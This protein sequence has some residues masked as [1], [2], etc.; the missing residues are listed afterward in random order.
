MTWL[1]RL[2]QG[3]KKPGDKPSTLSAFARFFQRK[4][5]D[6]TTLEDLETLLLEANFGVEFTTRFLKTCEKKLAGAQPENLQT[7]LA[8]EIESFVTPYMKPLPVPEAQKPFVILLLGVNGSGKT[9]SAGKLAAHYTGQGLKVMMAGADLF[10]AAAVEQA[11]IW[12]QRAGV[13]FFNSETHKDSAAL[14]YAACKE[15][16]E[17]QQDVLLLDTA[18]RLHTQK[19]LMDELEKLTRVIKKQDPAAPHATLLVLDGTVG[20][21]ALSQLSLFHETCPL[22]GI[23]LTK[24]DGTSKAGVVL[25]LVEKHRIPV[26]G[27]GLGEALED[28]CPPDAKLFAYALTG[29]GKE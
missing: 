22:T 16:K 24:M 26:V 21:N 1:K 15:A 27:F 9:T 20:Q 14:A 17:T 7:L 25:Q 28:L 11:E 6:A 29:A 18:G 19:N 4:K 12:A 8:A 5:L 13:A 23:I 3:F 10:R 2:T